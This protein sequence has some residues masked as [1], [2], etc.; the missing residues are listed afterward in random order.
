MNI[1]KKLTLKDLKLNKKRT[2]GTIIGVILSCALILVVGG[3]FFVLQDTL[4]EG[5]I[6]RDGYYHV[7]IDE[8]TDKQVQEL[9]SNR[10][11][12]DVTVVNKVGVGTLD[13][14]NYDMGVESYN[15]SSYSQ[16]IFNQLNYDVLEGEFPKNSKEILINRGFNYFYDKEVGDVIE[17]DVD[18][19]KKSYMVSGISD[20]YDELIT[21][22]VD[23]TTFKAFLTLKNPNNYFEDINKLLG[24]K[25]YV[26]EFESPI[27][28]DNYSIRSDLIMY[29]TLSYNNSSIEILASLFAVAIFVIMVTSIFAIRNSFAISVSEKTKMYGMLSSVGA[30]KK[31]IKKMVLFE[32]FVV[33]LIGTA[34]GILL[35][36]FVTWFLTFIIN[37]IA[38]NAGL[39]EDV[40]LIYNFSILPV[41]IAI[42]MS[43]IVIYLSVISGARRASKTSPIQNIRNASDI[44]RKK[45]R[46]PKIIN[47]IFGIGGVISYKNL[48]RSKKKY[49]VTI[50]S[51]TVSIF[52]FIVASSLIEY[53]LKIVNYEYVD[54]KYNVSIRESSREDNIKN[55]L[56]ELRKIDNSYV[57]YGGY[58]DYKFSDASLINEELKYV[59]EIGGEVFEKVF[60]NFSLYDDESFRKIMKDLN[61]DYEYMKDKIIILNKIK[62]PR[63]DDGR[64][65]NA[66]YYKKGDVIELIDPNK[67]DG[68]PIKLVVGE[69]LNDNYPIGLERRIQDYSLNMVG[70]YEYMDKEVFQY[71][72]ISIYY[73]SDDSY[74]LAD[75]IKDINDKIYVDNIEES[76]SQTRSLILILS[77]VAYSFIGVLTLI[78]VTSVF[79]TI[80]SN[81]ELRKSEFATLKS[82]GMTKKE[83]NRMINLESFF[84]SFKSLFYGIVLGLIGSYVVFMLFKDEYSFSYLLP[85]QS[86]ILAVLFV[87]VIVLIIMRYSIKKI[88][89]YNIIETIRNNNV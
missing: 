46:T 48:K 81:M 34:L 20:R 58:G 8:L 45:I 21:T 40:T 4:V 11:F 56:E 27:Y 61:L 73:D 51:L 47:K 49:R 2:L 33:G 68:K 13:T 42:L 75:K 31:Q 72:V 66:T 15:I 3:F 5:E 69:L 18:G 24:L 59:D 7:M 50:I 38:V 39:L 64:F 88:N 86:I 22:G 62:N 76:A 29:E 63:E 79:N 70:N 78:G 60:Y 23:S 35:G 67:Q 71:G 37:F 36:I 41:I 77:I 89:K 57:M 17:L 53:G 6:K 30:T 25:S 43:V 74:A 10:D 1:L 14:D 83:F 12:S 84:Y 28:G 32:G 55:N 54:L 26:D 82:V 44:K 65:I 80:N 85:V 19:V 9:K 16:E 52:I 87:V